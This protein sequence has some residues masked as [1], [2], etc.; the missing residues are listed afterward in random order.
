MKSKD[1]F[2]LLF[3]N[4]CIDREC[5]IKKN[6][7]QRLQE[8]VFIDPLTNLNN[9]NYLWAKS[10]IF[11]S[12]AQRYKEPISCFIVDFD[13]FKTI[14]DQYGH[15]V[16]DKVL[17]DV[18]Q[19]IKGKV[20]VSDI[21]VRFGGDEI[22]FLLFK[23]NKKNALKMAEKIRET[24]E[25][26][27]IVIEKSIAVKTTISIGVYTLCLKEQK[28]LQTLDEIINEADKLLYVAKKNGKNR[29]EHN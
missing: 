17:K 6:I 23:M 11:I 9:R 8:L 20:R 24:V 2:D 28:K 19:I 3:S 12:L 15:L 1:K 21:I 26:L 14:N 13:N 4:I 29:V 10:D 22:L 7:Y 27:D 16:G 18:S 25:K 5:P